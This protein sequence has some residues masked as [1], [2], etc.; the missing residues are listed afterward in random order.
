MLGKRRWVLQKETDKALESIMV[1]QDAYLLYI[2][3]SFWSQ[4]IKPVKKT[5]PVSVSSQ[6]EGGKNETSETKRMVRSSMWDTVCSI[7]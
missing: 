5:N 2:S 4:K 3:H 7:I 1:T 6:Q